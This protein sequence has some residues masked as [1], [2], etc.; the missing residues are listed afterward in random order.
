MTEKRFFDF[1]SRSFEH[2]VAHNGDGKVF[3]ERV[4]A[5]GTETD[6]NFLDLTILPPESSIGIHTHTTDNEEID[7][8]I[9]GSGEM[10]V[11]NQKFPVSDGSVIAN[12]RGGTHGLKNI[13]TIDLKLVVLEFPSY[14]PNT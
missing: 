1:E 11:G 4:M 6:C 9:S 3:T 8:V 7:I 12:P 10:Y 13:G 2:V 5:R 14:D